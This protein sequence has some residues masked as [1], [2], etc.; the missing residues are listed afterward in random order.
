LFLFQ[1][2]SSEEEVSFS[3]PLAVACSPEVVWNKNR[4]ERFSVSIRRNEWVLLS[5][6]RKGPLIRAKSKL[7]LCIST[8]QCI[9]LIWTASVEL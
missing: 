2:S 5:I 3:R 7:L 8:Q 4:Y 9:S 6:S 1:T